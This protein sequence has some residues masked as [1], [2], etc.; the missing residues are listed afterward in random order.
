MYSL[1]L[2]FSSP[3][4]LMTEFW[5]NMQTHIADNVSLVVFDEAHCICVWGCR[6]R[7]DYKKM[8]ILRESFPCVPIMALSATMPLPM[9]K[10]IVKTLGMKSSYSVVSGPLNRSNIYYVIKK[11]EVLSLD[12]ASI[13]T[14]I[15]NAAKKEDLQKTIIFCL[16]KEA[17]HSIFCHLC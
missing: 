11:K 2:V 15:D 16:S 6:F 12:L 1:I 10:A 8:K 4:S 7:P 3:E 9:E 14:D 13:V 17:C 5:R